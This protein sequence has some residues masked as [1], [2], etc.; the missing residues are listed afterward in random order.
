VAKQCSGRPRAA[1]SEL[2]AAAR[3]IDMSA[4]IESAICHAA[5]HAFIAA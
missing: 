2:H 4:S 3:R 5:D 1:A